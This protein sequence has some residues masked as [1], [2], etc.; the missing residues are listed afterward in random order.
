MQLGQGRGST[1]QQG[2]TYGR[3]QLKGKITRRELW[4]GLTSHEVL[5]I[6]SLWE[7]S[8]GWLSL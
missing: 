3:R 4:G 5:K 8:G 2:N 6:F 7:G 1:E